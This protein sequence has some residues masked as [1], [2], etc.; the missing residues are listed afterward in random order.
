MF[1][2]KESSS[3]NSVDWSQRPRMAEKVPKVVTGKEDGRWSETGR[4]GV[5]GSVPS[6]HC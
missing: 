3:K 2:N 4:R 1:G 5:P 6:E